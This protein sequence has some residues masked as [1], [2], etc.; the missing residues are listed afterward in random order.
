MFE[1]AAGDDKP[2]AGLDPGTGMLIATRQTVTEPAAPLARCGLWL[3]H[4]RADDTGRG[5]KLG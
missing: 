2:D 5:A 4:L 3:G 1:P